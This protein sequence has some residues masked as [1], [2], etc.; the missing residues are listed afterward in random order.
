MAIYECPWCER[1][2]FSFWQKQTLGPTRSLRCEQC[3]RKV[4]VCGQRA[5]IAA[6]P[7]FLLG[8]LGLLLGQ[9][10]FGTWPAVLLGGWVGVTF[11]MLVAAPIYHV[12]VPLERQT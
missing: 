9:A 3:K 8:F 7:L 10:Y 2:A 12:Y 6:A 5:Q 1:K 11:G 4:G